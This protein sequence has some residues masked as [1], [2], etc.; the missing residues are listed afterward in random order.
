MATLGSVE[1]FFAWLAG[2]AAIALLPSLARD[3]KRERRFY[4]KAIRRPAWAPRETLVFS[5]VWTVLYVLQALA[6][7]RIRLLGAWLSGVNL[8]ALVVYVVLQVALASYTF[9]FFGLQSLWASTLSTFAALVLALIETVFAFR[10]DTLSGIIFVALD[11]WLLY[12]FVL[13][14]TILYLTNGA[15]MT[16]RATR[17][18]VV[19]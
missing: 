3:P 8:G 2:T 6:A 5:V 9:F 13:S 18:Q 12:A 17:S 14:A 11:V 1:L 16:R 19:C 15:K 7:T 10:L 4:C